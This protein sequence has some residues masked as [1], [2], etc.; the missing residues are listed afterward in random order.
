[1]P[2]YIDWMSPILSTTGVGSSRKFRTITKV[3]EIKTWKNDWKMT[4]YTSHECQNEILCL[5]ANELLRGLVR[6]IKDSYFSIICD[7]YTDISNNEQMGGYMSEYEWRLSDFFK[8]KNTE[9]LTI[10]KAILDS[11]LRLHLHVIVLAIHWDLFLFIRDYWYGKRD[12]KANKN[13]LT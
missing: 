5:M 4:K 12:N 6:E 3:K 11:L 13:I 7:E 10:S 9:A 1:M 8:L 2:C